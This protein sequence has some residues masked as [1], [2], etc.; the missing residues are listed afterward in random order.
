VA[1]RELELTIDSLAAGGDGVGRDAGGKVMF[2]PRTA[3]GDRVRVAVVQETASFGRGELREIL[4]PSPARR[5]PG[6]PRF[7][8]G[9]GGC[10]WLHVDEAAQ[11]AAKQAQVEAALRRAV[12]GDGLAIRPIATPVPALG[13]RRRTR[14]HVRGGRLGFYAAR[15]QELVEVRECPQ[16][17]ARLERALPAI[18]AARPPDG[19]LAMAVGIGDRVA[20]AH[21]RAWPA[22][23]ALIGQANLAGVAAGGAS[24]GEPVLELEPGLFGRADAFAQASAEGNA[25]II[26]AAIEALGDALGEAL[27]DAPGEA[28]ATVLEL[29][30][31]A[32]N[33]T[34]AIRAAGWNVVA[35]DVVAPA[36]PPA[37]VEWIVADAAAA[38][39]QLAERRG[40]FAAI[41]LDPPRAGA[42]D[43]VEPVAALAAPR[44][45][46]VSCDV[47]TLARDAQALAAH[48]YRAVWAQPIDTMPQTAHL[49]V[50]V[51]FDYGAA[52]TPS[53]R[54]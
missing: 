10:Q 31:G 27:G 18:A 47:A 5:Q 52:K 4:R 3:P 44:L 30:A 37:G 1:P 13:W 17:D 19:E 42:R 23:A 36:Q 51:R 40:E 34:R 14:L 15:S 35:S 41:V 9:C 7:V 6:C 53:S 16:L 32:G 43:I 24:F 49:E 21:A 39:R 26:A 29:Y 33:L 45:V 28:A 25:A 48:G 22:A 38:M 12:A 50:V 2:V 8:A 11:H 20:L 46:Y 54:P